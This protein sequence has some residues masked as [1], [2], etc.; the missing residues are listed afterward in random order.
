MSKN[1][2][3]FVVLIVAMLLVCATVAGCQKATFYFEYNA[4]EGDWLEV[5]TATSTPQ[6]S[7]EEGSTAT[8]DLN[9][10]DYIDVDTLKVYNN[11]QEITWTKASDYTAPLTMKGDMIHVGCVEIASIANDTSLTFEAEERDVTFN[12]S[13]PS[14]FPLPLGTVDSEILGDLSINNVS[15]LTLTNSASSTNS[16]AIP[17]STLK[18]NNGVLTVDYKYATDVLNIT[19]DFVTLDGANKLSATPTM[20]NVGAFSLNCASND[21]IKSSYNVEV[22]PGYVNYSVFEVE[23]ET[24]GRILSVQGDATLVSEGKYTVSAAPGQQLIFD[25]NKS[26]HANFSNAHVTINNYIAWSGES[27]SADVVTIDVCQ[28]SPLYLALNYGHQVDDKYVVELYGATIDY[29]YFYGVNMDAKAYA[30]S[31]PYCKEST[32]LYF[33]NTPT[34]NCD[35]TTHTSVTTAVYSHPGHGDIS[36]TIADLL[37]YSYVTIEGGDLMYTCNDFSYVTFSLVCDA[38]GTPKRLSVKMQEH[39]NATISF[40]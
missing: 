5:V 15:L 7:I 24:V 8:L 29:N 28:I 40:N 34:I 26:S 31:T 14:Q 13:L 33:D 35:L 1:K 25:V 17:Y 16:V 2:K 39:S 27:S 23:V 11:D 22:D 10:A 12:F 32:Y 21:G 18:N 9:V 4:P 30:S 20:Q 37:T 3:L 38:E 6:G 19:G 36:K